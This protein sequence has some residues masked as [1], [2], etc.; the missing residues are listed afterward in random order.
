MLPKFLAANYFEEISRNLTNWQLNTA[1]V[2]VLSVLFGLLVLVVLLSMLLKAFRGSSGI[3][4][5]VFQV[6]SPSE[7][8]ALFEQAIDDRSKFELNFDP[9]SKFQ[10]I[11]SLVSI[12]SDGLVL[13]PPGNVV[14]KQS[15]VGR[16]VYLYFSVPQ[17]KNKRIFYHFISQV[18][19]IIKYNPQRV[20]LQISQPATVQQ[21]SKRNL[22]RIDPRPDSIRSLVVWPAAYHSSG[23]LVS[24]IHKFGDPLFE[25][26]SFEQ[27]K[28]IE[29][30]NI[31]G[32]GVRLKIPNKCRKETQFNPDETR[33]LVLF[34]S[35][36]GHD[37]SLPSNFYLLGRIRNIYQDFSTHDLEI[38]LQFVSL[39]TPQTDTPNQLTWSAIDSIQGV[40]DIVTWV[41]KEHLTLYR[42][43]G[44]A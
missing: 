34:V 4:K 20:F 27:H 37:N 36:A 41:M 5:P 1:A 11:C 31:S 7:I 10:S 15:W 12:Q 40:D 21:K 26:A 13:E 23:H 28:L 33:E 16:T 3:G 9:K 8:E 29:L 22:Y 30:V 19:D 14:P 24:D 25:L 6:D 42:E 35:L 38:G 18:T 43:K 2:A 17:G 32:G 44:I 39:G